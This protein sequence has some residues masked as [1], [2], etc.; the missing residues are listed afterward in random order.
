MP[1]I[2]FDTDEWARLRADTP[3]TLTETDLLHLQGI[4][5][6]VSM[7]EVERIYLPLSRLLSLY[8]EATQKLFD[9][10]AEF[11]GHP[12]AKVPFVVGMAGSVAVG[13]STTARIL[14]ELLCR[15]P[16]HPKVDLVTTDGFLLPNEE[17]ERRELMHRKG[18][19]ETYDI[20]ALVDF[21]SDVKAGRPQVKSPVYSHLAYDIVPGEY[22]TVDRPDIMIIEGLNVLESGATPGHRIPTVVLSDYFDFTIYVDA[23]V[24]HIRQWYVDRFLTLRDTA[25]QDPD[26]YF[27]QYADLSDEEAVD[28]AEEIWSNINERNLVENILP[29]RE[30]A[31]L[32]LRKA[33]DHSVERVRLRKI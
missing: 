6:Q 11:L 19:P 15:W 1:Y 28:F 18:F 13:K 32:I 31:D 17:L 16:Q 3:L 26:S 9:A 23:D 12:E 29:T 21:V 25:F 4:N 33:A 20:S 2:E 30:R 5:E 14:R 7:S 8:V 27:H 10:T 22:E 24:A